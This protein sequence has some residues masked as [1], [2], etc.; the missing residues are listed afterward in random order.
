MAGVC[1]TR[2]VQHSWKKLW[3]GAGDGEG[4]LGKREQLSKASLIPVLSKSS[5][6]AGNAELREVFKIHDSHRIPLPSHLLAASQAFLIPS[7]ASPSSSPISCSPRRDATSP[8]HPHSSA[9]QVNPVPSCQAAAAQPARGAGGAHLGQRLVTEGVLCSTLC[10]L[11][12]EMGLWLC[13][14]ASAA[15]LRQPEQ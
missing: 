7:E 15:C 9:A 11:K 10:L 2:A 4:N 13:S 1:L 8:S 6:P 3:R 12:D 5:D 14:N